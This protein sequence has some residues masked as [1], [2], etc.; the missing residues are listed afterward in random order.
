[1]SEHVCKKH[2]K[3]EHTVD[4]IKKEDWVFMEYSSMRSHTKCF[5]FL[6][7]QEDD[8]EIYQDLLD[9]EVADEIIVMDFSNTY[10][11][12]NLRPKKNW[13]S[14]KISLWENF[15]I[16]NRTDDNMILQDIKNLKNLEKARWWVTCKSSDS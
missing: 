12:R 3:L 10:D 7:V 14:V 13:T 5:L 1:M 6:V 4:H 8:A 15:C 2:K 16:Q 11:I 9:F